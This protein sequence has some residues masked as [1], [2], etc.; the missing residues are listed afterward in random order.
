M[1]LS[2]SHLSFDEY[3]EIEIFKKL[4]SNNINFIEIVFSK[5]KNWDELKSKDVLNY[6]QKLESF[7]LKCLSS[8]SLFYNTGIKSINEID[9]I[10]NHFYRIINYS[11]IL[12][13]KTLV[14]GSPNIRKKEIGWEDSISTIF[15]KLDLFLEDKN[16]T[17]VIEPNSKIYGGE[18]FIT[19]DEIVK[20]IVKENLKKIK[21]MIDT[22]NLI[23]ENIS[24]QKMLTEYHSY[25]SHIHISEENLQPIKLNEFHYDFNKTIKEIGYNE[26]ITYEVLKCDNLIESINIFSSIYGN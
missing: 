15:K 6:K 21:T 25:I 10:L 20:F 23:L 22:H 5:I 12:G 26:T 8:Q 11:E 13:I 1:N 3:N 9:L 14:F 7:G 24:P 16:L 4:K 18:F 2:I 17:I 19:V